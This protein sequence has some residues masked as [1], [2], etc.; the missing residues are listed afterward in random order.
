MYF[1]VNSLHIY[2]Y[3]NGWHICTQVGE[4]TV[5]YERHIKQLQAEFSK[6]KRNPQ[7]VFELMR[8]TFPHR[9][10]EILEQ[11][12]DLT[13]MFERFPFLQEIDHVSLTVGIM[14]IFCRFILST[15]V[16]ITTHILSLPFT[17]LESNFTLYHSIFTAYAGAGN[18]FRHWC[19]RAK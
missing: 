18:D 1:I 7:V 10:A 11:P 8:K 4:D 16:I 13:K 14:H 12:S 9:R 6:T 2:S 17:F 3:G 19:T 15:L 5:S